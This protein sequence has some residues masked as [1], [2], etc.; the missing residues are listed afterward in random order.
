M[1]TGRRINWR[2]MLV[3][4]NYPTRYDGRDY[5]RQV[6]W[7]SWNR[8]RLKV[9]IKLK[10][11]ITKEIIKCKFI[12]GWTNWKSRFWVLNSACLRISE[13]WNGYENI[14]FWFSGNAFAG[15]REKYSISLPS[16]LL[17]YQR[18]YRQKSV[19]IKNIVF[20]KLLRFYFIF[21]LAGAF[22]SC[23]TNNGSESKWERNRAHFNIWL[24]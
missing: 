12:S 7:P 9:T 16:S 23:I 1:T 17:F 22:L 15:N 8:W 2:I 11:W 13:D 19:N 3:K 14:L 10:Y 20:V 4:L 5:A 6:S 24:F 21:F 18:R